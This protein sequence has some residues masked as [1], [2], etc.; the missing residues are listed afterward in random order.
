MSTAVKHIQVDPETHRAAKMAAIQ[1]GKTLKDW[2]SELI[3][4][5]TKKEKG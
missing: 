3:T 4:K 2:V 5:A 1:S